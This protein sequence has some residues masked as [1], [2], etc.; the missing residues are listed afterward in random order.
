MQMVGE[1]MKQIVP[2]LGFLA[3]A[4]FAIGSTFFMI[5]KS[6]YG[7][8]T[9][10]EIRQVLADNPDIPE[11]EF[12]SLPD[13]VKSS[14]RTEGAVPY[15]SVLDSVRFAFNFALGNIMDAETDMPGYDWFGQ[16]AFVFTFIF[17]QI[18]LLNLLIA[19]IGSVYEKKTEVSKQEYYRSKMQL[20][21]DLALLDDDNGEQTTEKRESL[22]ENP[23]VFVLSPLAASN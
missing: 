18:L 9:V 1:S 5:S 23:F 21:L 13:I 16:V 15:S 2:F 10:Y 4:I 22:T 11:T 7:L 3:A 8:D 19:I 14:D 17:I 6:Y 12:E 20:L